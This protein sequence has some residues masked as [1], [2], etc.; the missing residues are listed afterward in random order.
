[1]LGY[2][3]DMHDVV[4]VAC[5]SWREGPSRIWAIGPAIHFLFNMYNQGCYSRKVVNVV[6]RTIGRTADRFTL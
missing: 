5:V 1:M 2:E 6:A 4:R 3:P